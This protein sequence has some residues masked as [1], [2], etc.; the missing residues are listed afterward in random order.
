[1]ALRRHIVAIF[2]F[3]KSV[4][5]FMVDVQAFKIALTTA[6]GNTHVTIPPATITEL[7]THLATLSSDE[8]K[9]AT[10]GIGLAVT[11]DLSWDVV[12]KD[13]RDLVRIVQQVMDNAPDEQ[14]AIAIAH[15]C[16]LKTKAKGIHVKSDLTVSNDAGGAGLLRLV[17]RA[18]GKN[19]NAA[20]EWQSSFNGVAFTTFKITIESSTLWTSNAAPGTKMYFRRRIIV[21]E[22]K[23]GMLS[24]SQIVFV[25]V[26]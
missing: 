24:W 13:V 25:I 17:S 10:K 12:I 15:A 4:P 2:K 21:S 22:K 3:S 7:E 26:I 20:Y 5:V 14:H 23:G 11:R 8:A 16:G 19:I 9:S 1:M 6:P 18:A